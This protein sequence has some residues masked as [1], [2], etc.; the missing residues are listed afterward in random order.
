MLD[1]TVKVLAFGLGLLTFLGGL[2]AIA[3]GGPVALSGIWAVLFGSA[4]MVATLM[5]RG[6]YRSEAAERSHSDPGPGGGES[7]VIEPR[8][9]TS[10]EV[11]TDP[12]TGHVMRVFMDPRTGERLY[13]AES[14]AAR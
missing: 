9:M 6:R 5:Q 2:V 13:R 1:A 4:V 11:F 14:T 8:F 3:A 7:G 12:T 10:T